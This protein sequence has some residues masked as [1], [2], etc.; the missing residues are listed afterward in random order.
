MSNYQTIFNLLDDLPKYELPNAVGYVNDTKVAPLYYRFLLYKPLD[1]QE[2]SK[3][4]ERCNFNVSDALIDI[5][6]YCNGLRINQKFSI[7]GSLLH[8]GF[9]PITLDYGNLNERPIDLPS[10][11]TVIG[12]LHLS[13]DNIGYLVVHKDGSV[14]CTSSFLQYD[15]IKS[16]PDIKALVKDQIKEALIEHEVCP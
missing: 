13:D 10:S 11:A 2:L 12:A 16:W 14:I 9:Q 4:I 15:V 7:F 5:Y 1:D 3:F 6:K 8:K